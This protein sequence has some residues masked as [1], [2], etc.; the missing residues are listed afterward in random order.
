LIVASV[1]ATT[2]GNFLLETQDGYLLSLIPTA[3]DPDPEISLLAASVRDEL[4][5]YFAKGRKT[6]DVP[7]KPTGTAFQ[8]DIWTALREKVGFGILVTYKQ[9]AEL[10][11]HPMAFRA[12][13]TALNHNP[14]PI[15]IP[16]HRV[17]KTGGEYGD[18]KYG[19]RWKK[20][21]IELEKSGL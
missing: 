17:V 12:V 16:C 4:N 2:K 10:S 8:K 14:I 19:K 6:F 9:L 15:I 7:I 11:G 5:G 18:Y 13:G 21:L 1:I 20:E 3:K